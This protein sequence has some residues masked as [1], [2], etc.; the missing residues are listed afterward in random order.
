[1]PPCTRGPAS[2]HTHVHTAPSKKGAL[3]TCAPI[4]SSGNSGRVGGAV[5]FTC[6]GGGGDRWDLVRTGGAF[7]CGGV[8]ESV[9]HSHVRRNC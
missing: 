8:V 4:G 9:G 7:M 5:L 1:M 2:F 3:P 6:E